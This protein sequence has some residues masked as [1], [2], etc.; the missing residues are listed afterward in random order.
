MLQQTPRN[1]KGFQSIEFSEGTATALS[2]LPLES[3]QA[4]A[5]IG[6]PATLADRPSNASPAYCTDEM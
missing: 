1:F 2:R 3:A 6:L 4:W 5:A